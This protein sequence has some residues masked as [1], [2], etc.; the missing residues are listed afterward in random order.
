MVRVMCPRCGVTESVSIE[1]VLVE[2]GLRRLLRAGAPRA[3]FI[4]ATCYDV[5]PAPISRV[6]L[7]VAAQKA[8]WASWLSVAYGGARRPGWIGPY[9][10][11]IGPY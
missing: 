1:A 9:S 10:G 6:R 5:V 2:T 4:C 8:L 7:A 11:W 3:W